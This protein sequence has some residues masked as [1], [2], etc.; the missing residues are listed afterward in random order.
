M[1]VRLLVVG[2]L[3]VASPLAAAEQ[4]YKWVDASG[5]VT[6]SSTPP[7]GAA[8]QTVDLPPAPPPAEIEAARERERSLQELGDQMSQQR[9]DR[10][11]Q[12]AQERQAASAAAAL[13]PPAQPPQDA[14]VTG[15]TDWWI[16]GY[17]PGVRP[18]FPPGRPVRPPPG[19]DPTQPPDNPVYWPREPRVPPGPRPMPLR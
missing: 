9:Q 15:D 6:Y 5:N 11:A 3:L 8:A 10:E 12:A 1:S 16:P 19:S 14:G 2:M 4:I 13:Q 18:P 17:G 7:P